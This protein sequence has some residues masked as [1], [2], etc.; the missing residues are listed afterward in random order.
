MV[1]KNLW[2][3]FLMK[4]YFLASV[5]L[6]SLTT[7]ASAADLAPYTKAPMAEPGINWSGFYIGAMGGYGWSDSVRATVGGLTASTSSSDL[8][9]GF[10]GGTIG[11]NWQTGQIVFGIETDAAWSDLKYSETDFGV[12]FTDKIQ[13]FGSVTGR[14]GFTTGAA[15]FYA[16]G[17]Y[18]WA[19]NQISAAGFGLTGS[20]SHMHD[21]WTIGGGLEY[22]FAPNWSGKIEYMYADYSNATYLA[23][24]GGIGLGVTVNTVKAGVNYH[25]GAPVVARY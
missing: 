10:G 22:M 25:F 7:L 23:S 16:K 21:G 8:N 9:G 1:A 5:A 14:I 20:E 6:I 15:L 2:G 3:N 24:L 18:A 11:Y 19:E 17:G 13:S 12:T 4:K